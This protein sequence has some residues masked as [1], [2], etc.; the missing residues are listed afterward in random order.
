MGAGEP[1]FDAVFA[2][3]RKLDEPNKVYMKSVE[4]TFASAGSALPNTFHVYNPN[5]GAGLN[6]QIAAKTSAGAVDYSH[7]FSGVH[8]TP[9]NRDA[10]GK[11]AQ[12]SGRYFSDGSGQ[13]T[14][15]TPFSSAGWYRIHFDY[16]APNAN[17]TLFFNA[18]SAAGAPLKIGWVDPA[19]EANVGIRAIFA[20]DQASHTFFK[21]GAF[22]NPQPAMVAY[23][24]N[25]KVDGRLLYRRTF[26]QDEF[27]YPVGY[28]AAGEHTLTA[29]LTCAS[30]IRGKY[31]FG[32]NETSFDPNHSKTAW[33]AAQFV[34]DGEMRTG[35]YD[36]WNEGVAFAQ[37]TTLVAGVRPPPV[38]RGN[39]FTVSLES[40]LL[41]GT[42]ANA[43]LRI[44]PLGSGSETGWSATRIAASDYTGGIYTTGG[45]STR[46]RELWRVSVPSNAAV[47]RY[48]LRA[49][50][51]NGSRVGN[52]VL[53]YVIHNPL[54]LLNSYP[55]SPSAIETYAYDDDFDGTRMELDGELDL[56]IDGK[57]DQLIAHYLGGSG[58]VPPT[59]G[60]RV[61]VTGAFQRTDDANSFS[62][63][64]YAVA[65]ASGTTDE[66]Q[67]MRRLY[68]IV[69]QRF[70]YGGREVDDPSGSFV[71][72]S[73]PVYGFTPEHAFTYS[74]PGTA[75]APERKTGV[76]CYTS[77][78]SLVSLARSVGLLSRMGVSLDGLGGWGDHGFA[79][80][81]IPS[82]PQH[83]GK[84]QASDSS[85]GSDSEHW[86][87]FDP[88]SPE[89]WG[90]SQEWTRYSEAVATQA[91]Y[92]RAARILS[93][94]DLA[95]YN[96]VTSLPGWDPLW[97]P[98]EPVPAGNVLDESA[99]F[100][101]GP[102][103]W[104]TSFSLT[105]WLGRGEKDVYRI[106]KA[107]TG[108]R[109]VR[110][111][112]LPNDG[113]YL[114]PK[115]CVGSS[116]NNPVMPSRCADAGTHYPLPA[117]ESTIVVFSD[118][119]NQPSLWGDSVQYVL[120]LEY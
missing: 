42:S 102:E 101:S 54:G 118:T 114:V 21:G 111:R 72:G 49:F 84:T 91:Q 24:D 77:A 70:S 1:K 86:Y 112:S 4:L 85:P 38:R 103:F 99:S 61:I 36:A 29:S 98:L 93:G 40:A 32:I 5:D 90:A 11:W 83:G 88:T 8:V 47:G 13:G 15:Y 59:Y 50:A 52:D 14:Y 35:D 25:I 51:P 31:Y 105:G 119:G 116:S 48:V 19:G 20:V 104:M 22:K 9:I 18:T 87:V 68:R 39:I 46:Y 45:F 94:N 44:Y 63:L 95:P 17:R 67:T 81:F 60:L 117:G 3:K 110:V 89:G 69:S 57:R 71:G 109:A 34:Y 10:D 113:A 64:D 78:A 79:E 76:L 73:D 27:D 37:G 53:F 41:N 33:D 106:S 66:F 97:S 65:A 16:N 62:M 43:T 80:A 30:G 115:L 92:G 55:L 74:R 28:L 56:D 12:G 108:A 58:S 96:V 120:E 82:I 75:L 7:T 6:F 26:D 23:A 100:Q 107:L 2:P